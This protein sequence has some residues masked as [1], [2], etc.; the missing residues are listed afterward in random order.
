MTST[1]IDTKSF[2]SYLTIFI[3]IFIFLAC[4]SV[5]Y[6]YK[7]N[8]NNPPIRSDGFGYY[9]YLTSLFIDQDLSMKSAI[10]HKPSGSNAAYGLKL[11]PETGRILNK[12]TIGTALLQSPFFIVAHISAAFTEFEQSGYSWPY[13]IANICA[14]I[15]FAAIGIG[16][17]FYLLLIQGSR[18]KESILTITTIVFATNL[19]HYSSYDASFSHIYSFYLMSL[20]LSVLFL[21]RQQ[22]REVSC[23]PDQREFRY[24]LILGGLLGVIALVRVPNAIIALFPIGIIAEKTYHYQ[25]YRKGI[26]Q[27][28][29]V[30][31]IAFIT[32]LPQIIYWYYCSGHL[33]LNSYQGE[34][35][36]WLRPEFFNFLFSVRKGLFFWSPIL[37][38]SVAGL[39]ML[40]KRD[41]FLGLLTCI[42]LFLHVYICSSWWS[43]WFGGSF[44]SRP[45][46]DFLPLFAIP[47]CLIIR[48]SISKLGWF[49][50]SV[51]ILGFVFL[52][53]SL[54]LGY[55]HG[56]I[57]FDGT[58]MQTISHFFFQILPLAIKKLTI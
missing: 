50:C 55:W 11:Y 3:A 47:L 53:C 39:A 31:I 4:S 44:G 25:E 1:D 21:Y 41:L 22:K 42:V 40:L 45:I 15:T 26:K 52:N 24:C 32:F 57:P 12:Y 58:T 13:Q 29:L 43:W 37:I 16:A 27:L 20:F 28:S 23:I 30:F 17:V 2:F 33:I 18:P 14:G 7:H 49:L 54:M 6:I 51:I 10:E 36:N 9:A 5:F 35:F 46:V 34:Q 38:L 48:W 56:Y 19:F 8:L